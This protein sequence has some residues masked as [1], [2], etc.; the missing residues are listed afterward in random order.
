MSFLVASSFIGKHVE[1]NEKDA[2]ENN[3]TGEVLG[4]V[5]DQGVVKVRI[6]L[7]DSDEIQ[8]FTY[9]KIVKASNTKEEI[10]PEES[11]V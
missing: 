6:K 1:I 4:V 10:K 7:H 9:D 5:K 11:E 2:S 8:E 3:K